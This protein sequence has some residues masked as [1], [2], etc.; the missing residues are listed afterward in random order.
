MTNKASNMSS[1]TAFVRPVHPKGRLKHHGHATLI[2]ILPPSVPC[3][4]IF[5][6]IFSLQVTILVE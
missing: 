3:H 2:F 5:C 1:H 6:G 4:L